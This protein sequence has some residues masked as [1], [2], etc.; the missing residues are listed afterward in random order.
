M[1]LDILRHLCAL[2]GVSGQEDA[3]RG[4]IIEALPDGA[5]YIVDRLGNLIVTKDAREPK[6]QKHTALFA[7]M[8]EVGMIVTHVAPGGFL[9]FSHVGGID[10]RAYLGKRVFVGK[11]EIAGVIGVKPVH[12]LDDGEKRKTPKSDALCIDIGARSDVEAAERV[13]LGD[14][15]CFAPH[16]KTFGDGFVKAKAIDDRVG[17]AIL[18]DLLQQD[19]PYAMTAVFSCQEEVGGA[20]GAAAFALVPDYAIVVET[21]TA[22]DLPGVDGAKRVCALGGGAVVPFMDRGTVYPMELY[23]RTMALAAAHGIPAQTKTMIAGGNDAR[24]IH[25]GGCGVPTLAISV[26]C[27]YL[28]S[29]SVVM[30]ISDAEAAQSLIYHVWEELCHP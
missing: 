17:C 9:L 27:R 12:L 20:A 29:P 30:Q 19:L 16:F 6:P 2:S 7:H 5:R 10:R 4:A 1:N 18:L 21:T 14:R 3:V 23:M 11:N 28:H 25:T 15:V 22:N 8:D 13:Q 26:P 24:V